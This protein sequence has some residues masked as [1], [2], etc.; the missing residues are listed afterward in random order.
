MPTEPS[1]TERVK[2]SIYLLVTGV[3]AAGLAWAFW[4][5]LGA[6]GFIILW[7]VTGTALT[8]DNMKLR[9]QLRKLREG[10]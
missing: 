8:A 3:V 1:R 6:D 9:R 4:R 7:A 2:D 5:Y 10:K